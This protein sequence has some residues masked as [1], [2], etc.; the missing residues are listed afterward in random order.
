MAA[1]RI[2]VFFTGAGTFFFA[3][4]SALRLAASSAPFA[5][6]I[7]ATS[8]SASASR[9]DGQRERARDR[10]GLGGIAAEALAVTVLRIAFLGAATR[11]TES[12][13]ET[14]DIIV[15]WKRRA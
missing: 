3:R 1:A 2:F 5:S 15:F 12:G 13:V 9:R 11:A 10:G 4:S 6:A 8:P 7:C 14:R